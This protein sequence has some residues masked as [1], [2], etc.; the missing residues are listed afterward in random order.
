VSRPSWPAR[1]LG[2]AIA[3][4]A[5]LIAYRYVAGHHLL[6]S[7]RDLQRGRTPHP[8]R[9][10]RPAR[11]RL[12]TPGIEWAGTLLLIA[13]LAVLSIL[14]PCAAV[15][16]SR[17]RWRRRLS[18]A[19]CRFELRLG[20]EDLAEPFEVQKA[21]DG[22]CGLWQA[23]WY[24]RLWRGQESL[25]VET[26]RVADGSVRL[27]FAA[28]HSSVASLRGALGA[29]YPD[30]TLV[31]VGD[32]PTGLQDV[33]RLKKARASELSIQTVRNYQHSFTEALIA[34]L[35]EQPG[36]ASVQLVLTPAPRLFARRARTRLKERERRL[37]H[38]GRTDPFEPG[39]ASVIEAKDLKGAL[40]TAGGNSLFYCEIR[41]ASSDAASAQRIAGLFAQLRSE[42]E[43]VPRRMR[44]RRSL[45][46]RRLAAAA[47]NPLPGWGRGV[48][49]SSELATLW[50]LPGARLKHA[51][52]NRAQVRRAAAP[53]AISRAP[54]HML[55][56]DENGPVG[57][58]PE[59][60]KYGWALVGGQGGGKTSAMAR[61]IANDARDPS[62]AL[63]VLDPKEDLARL[64]LGTIP[65]DRLVHYLDLG[66]P[67]CGI[68]PLAARG[69]PGARADLF[70]R[71][72][73][74]ANP[75][76]AI[77]AASDSFLRQ[78][79]AAV[80]HAVPEPTL[81]HVYR[82]FETGESAFR[83]RIVAAL[84]RIEGTDFARGYWRHDFPAVA[85]DRGFAAAALNPPR[86]KL[87]RLISTSQIDVLLRHPVALDIDRIVQRGEVLIVNGAKNE[88][89]DDNARLVM[90]LLL[91]LVQRALQ[92][93]QRVPTEERR[94][95]ALYVDEAHN[96]L[97]PSRATMLAEGRSAGLEPTFAWQ[98]N[99][100]IADEVVR[101][102]VR[103]L[104]QSVSIFRMREIEDARSMAGLAMQV[105][106]D[107]IAADAD[108][109]ERL[110]FSVDDILAQPAHHAINLWLA[111]GRPQPAFTART[112]PAETLHAPE[113]AGAHLAAQR[114]RGGF[115]PP[116]LPD[117]T[118][119]RED[120]QPTPAGGRRRRSALR[121]AE[122]SA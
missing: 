59:D 28:Q 60:R 29:L 118:G 96:V 18:A 17:V 92:A 30:A 88:V 21:F 62:K 64:A 1:V 41:V 113:L 115:C 47:P 72:L 84:D 56:R 103:S 51:P 76:G 106:A 44:A 19:T 12:A 25:A 122:E 121:S 71:A 81:W 9:P 36:V 33:V 55:L 7:W 120:V 2:L 14:A 74:E 27:T 15:T 49:S 70:V 107:R 90:H 87:E 4:L 73:I 5:G 42:N 11:P 31:R 117:P 67:E 97:S 80:C 119:P 38:E 23:R 99:A 98:Y 111:G 53:R 45:Y 35:A 37:S 13:R 105:Y 108:E 91:G 34:L 43:L 61:G 16:A 75:P 77:Q 83:E 93:Q 52:L 65:A 58:L 104:L 63:I 8:A 20:R 78:A 102:G 57:L 39:A 24:Q 86:N 89:G 22:I 112:E 6:H 50:Q 40:E 54:G 79:I 26:H 95:V 68:N 66:A 101:S 46:L 85:G 100:Q 3:G 82:M 69:T 94:R 114:E 32:A 10:L 48:L 109:Q 110:R 116:H